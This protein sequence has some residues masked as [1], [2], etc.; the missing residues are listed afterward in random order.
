LGKKS[1]CNSNYK[2]GPKRPRNTWRHLLPKSSGKN[3]KYQE[4][5]EIFATLVYTQRFG[6]EKNNKKAMVG[7]EAA[8]VGRRG[9]NQALLQ[10]RDQ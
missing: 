6:I 3:Q 1:E 4:K 2:L 8:G 9:V 10:Y 7:L 5:S